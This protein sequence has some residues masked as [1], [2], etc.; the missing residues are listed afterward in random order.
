[1]PRA[2]GAAF[3]TKPAGQ[4]DSGAGRAGASSA[5]GEKRPGDFQPA[6]FAAC[7]PAA[8]PP[9]PPVQRHRRRALMRHPRVRIVVCAVQHGLLCVPPPHVGAHHVLENVQNAHFH[10]R[11]PAEK[12][13]M[14]AAS[15]V[16]RIALSPLPRGR[17]GSQPRS[18]RQPVARRAGEP[19]SRSRSCSCCHP[20]NSL[21]QRHTTA[22]EQVVSDCD[23]AIVLLLQERAKATQML[24][25]LRGPGTGVASAELSAE[26]LDRI[27]RANTPKPDAPAWR[28]E[29]SD[30]AALPALGNLQC[31]RRPCVRPRS[32]S[33]SLSLS[34][35]PSL[36]L[37]AWACLCLANMCL[38]T[39]LTCYPTC[40][41]VLQ[42]PS[43]KDHAVKS[44]FQVCMCVCV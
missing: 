35:S 7:A 19:S 10:R 18:G 31:A 38:F 17:Q 9:P 23:E 6:F 8:L 37:S 40:C 24:A 41:L 22:C 42:P 20:A 36:S 29:K 32:L 4:G 27:Q 13:E 34:L 26:E 25:E 28:L 33:P 16:P 2:P 43:L 30:V 3:K 1:V 44:V 21:H 15:S 14:P 5:R 11:R 39:S 12:G